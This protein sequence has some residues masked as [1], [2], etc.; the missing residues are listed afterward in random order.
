MAEDEFTQ[1][2]DQSVNDAGEIVDLQLWVDEFEKYF[3]ERIVGEIRT[4]IEVGLQTAPYILI[5][6]AI[7]FLV[8]FWTGAD[9]TGTNYSSF[10]NT[11]FDGYGWRKSVSGT[12]MQDGSQPHRW[13]KSHHM[14]G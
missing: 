2:P 11:F 5:S 9:S 6:C 12:S 14:L 8:T 7:D 4:T 10:V 13:R 1:F 3:D